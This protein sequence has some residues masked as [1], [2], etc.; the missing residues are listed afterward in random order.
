[1]L[2]T[3]DKDFGELAFRSRKPAIGIILYRLSGLTNHQKAELVA[4]V[5]LDSKMNLFGN[6][7]VITSK[8]VRVKKLVHSRAF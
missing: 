6:F 8:Q 3:A 2:L 5:F 7:T 1:M 4:K